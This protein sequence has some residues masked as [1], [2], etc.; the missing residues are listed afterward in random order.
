MKERGRIFPPQMFFYS[1]ASEQTRGIGYTPFRPVIFQ[2]PPPDPESIVS[3]LIRT[4]LC[5][6]FAAS[7]QYPLR[8]DIKIRYDRILQ[9]NPFRRRLKGLTY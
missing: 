1:D 9:S 2:N 6:H 7:L 4:L 8:G 3:S 5:L